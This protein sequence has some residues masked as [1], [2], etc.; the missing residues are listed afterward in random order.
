LPTYR[1][2]AGPDDSQKPTPNFIP[3]WVETI[4]SY[5]SSTV[6]IKF[7]CP[8]MK[9]ISAGFSIAT[10][11]RSMTGSPFID[12]PSPSQ[13]TNIRLLKSSNPM[14][15]GGFRPWREHKWADNLAVAPGYPPAHRHRRKV[16]ASFLEIS[17]VVNAKQQ[18]TVFAPEGCYFPERGGIATLLRCS[19]RC[20][21]RE[22][23]NTH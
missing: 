12:T 8:R 22:W 14:N 7:D 5:K 20:N 11:F 13:S 17:Y 19:C 9:F 4:A 15:L 1:T 10:V 3:G 21:P 2:S 23:F 6:L 16:L 18:Y